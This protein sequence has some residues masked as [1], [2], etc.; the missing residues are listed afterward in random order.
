MVGPVIGPVLGL[1]IECPSCALAIWD[2]QEHTAATT[3]MPTKTSSTDGACVE[4][5]IFTTFEL[6]QP[7]PLVSVVEQSG[8]LA[9][10]GPDGA[11]G[12]AA[13]G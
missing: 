3:K 2:W 11:G 5:I 1:V 7:D 6:P 8:S 4:A 10:L 12:S 13:A 9:P